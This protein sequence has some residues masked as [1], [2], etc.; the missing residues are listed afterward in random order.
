MCHPVLF[1]SLNFFREHYQSTFCSEDTY[2]FNS[3]RLQSR[4]QSRGIESFPSRLPP[5]HDGL[6]PDSLSE[7]GDMDGEESAGVTGV[8]RTN[9]QLSP[10]GEASGQQEVGPS[11]QDKS[12][13]LS[14]TGSISR[15]Y[16]HHSMEQRQSSHA[17]V[18]TSEDN[19]N[20]RHRSLESSNT[21]EEEL[22]EMFHSMSAQIINFRRI[23][24][25][26]GW[27]V[28]TSPE[29]MKHD[30]LLGL[31]VGLCGAVSTF[32]SWNS[33]MI[34]LMKAGKVG[35]AVVGYVIGIQLGVISYRFGQHLAVY[36]FVWRCRRETKRDEK[37]GYG[38]RLRVSDADD[39][40]NEVEGGASEN[41][42]NNLGLMVADQNVPSVRAV[43]TS[44]FGTIL[45]ALFSALYFFPRHQQFSIS[46][47]FTPLGCLARWRLT[48]K[49][50]KILPG[51]PLGEC[52]HL[53]RLSKSIIVAIISVDFHAYTQ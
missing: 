44:V 15:G 42:R 22:D 26:D 51:F 12:S 32:S 7:I 49:Y 6:I 40:G 21:I 34:N 43:A 28:G 37:R 38:I 53:F 19:N 52:H 2:G 23:N 20:A 4:S 45:I 3:S 31:R 50:N 13:N 10:S 25:A 18:L 29:E 1:L 16:S 33:A 47:L 24:V 11:S 36:I 17:L 48:N 39:S 14:W 8:I 35:E 41:F 46:L 9:R 30:I 5:E 27:D